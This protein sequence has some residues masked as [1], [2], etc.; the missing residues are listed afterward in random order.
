MAEESSPRH[1]DSKSHKDKDSK[2]KDKS[3][4]EGGKSDKLER[5]S[6]AGKI[7]L[8]EDVDTEDADII[9]QLKLQRRGP[10]SFEKIKLIGKGGVGRVYLV[11]LRDTG[12]LFAMKVLKKTEMIQRNKV[13]R[14][15]TEREILATASHPF[16]TTLYYSFQSQSRLYF[17]MDFCAGGEFYRTIQSQPDGCL[18]EDQMRFYS[19]EVLLALEY[20]HALGFIYRDLKPENILLHADGHVRLADFDLSKTSGKAIDA[21][22]VQNAMGMGVGGSAPQMVVEPNFVTNSFVG[23]E[24]YLAP[25]VIVGKGHSASVDWWTFG[26]LMYEMLYGTTPFRGRTQNDT[27]RRIEAADVHFPN[28][29]RCTVSKDCKAII[30]KLLCADPRK[31]LGAYGGAAEIKAHPFWKSLKWPLIRNMVPPLM[32][33]L[34]SPIDLSAFPKFEDDDK[35]S[36]EEEIDA[37]E[38]DQQ[39]PFKDFARVDRHEKHEVE[40]VPVRLG[41]STSNLKAS[42]SIPKVDDATLAALGHHVEERSKS[43]RVSEHHKSPPSSKPSFSASSYSS[44]GHHDKEPPLAFSTGSLKKSTAD[45]HK[46]PSHP[47]LSELEHHSSHHHTSSLHSS[48]EI[49]RHSKQV[50]SH[51]KDK[52]KRDKKDGKASTQNS[53]SASDSDSSDEERSRSSKHSRSKHSS[54]ASSR[55]NSRSPPKHKTSS[56]HLSPIVS[57]RKTS[58][59]HDDLAS[60]ASKHIASPPGH[61]S[62]HGSTRSSRR[63][64][65]RKSSRKD[66]HSEPPSASHSRSPSIS[67]STS[68]TSEPSHKSSKSHQHHHD[69]FSGD[70]D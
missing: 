60:L 69:E 63:N 41:S 39:N 12:Q 23:T 4:K 51:H 32:P 48:K 59:S 64:S 44:P 19:A 21:R 14:V 40:D 24:E 10:G 55:R 28:H 5:K 54:R 66:K 2:Q 35:N 29:P 58:K 38:L 16:I 13:K 3:S 50:D 34:S 18:T 17:I 70:S 33:K 52:K 20:L 42:A 53:E 47:N 26:I 7:C 37:Q 43:P 67:D 27:F 45:L 11:R 36:D 22:V 56:S 57:S 68:S 46:S 62:S 65:S 31:R 6:T 8:P 9:D 1:R 61:A 15:L 49:H 30:K 25:E